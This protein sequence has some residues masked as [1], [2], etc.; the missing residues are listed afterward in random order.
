[1]SEQPS[2]TPLQLP[3]SVVMLMIIIMTTVRRRKGEIEIDI[4]GRGGWRRRVGQDIFAGSSCFQLSTLQKPSRTRV[5]SMMIVTGDQDD[6]SD[7]W[8]LRDNNDTNCIG[9]SSN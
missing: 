4:T 2:A 7:W 6:D 3:Q 8:S 1:M 9:N 5:R